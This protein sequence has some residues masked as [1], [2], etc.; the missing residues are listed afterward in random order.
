MIFDAVQ[1]LKCG[2]HDGCSGL[3]WNFLGADAQP[4]SNS[5]WQSKA[6]DAI[7]AVETLL[8]HCNVVLL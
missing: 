5:G 7:D 6:S 4:G 1:E 3:V 8:D 2:K